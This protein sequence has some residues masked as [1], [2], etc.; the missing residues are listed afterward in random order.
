MDSKIVRFLE[1]N[2]LLSLA[3]EGPYAANCF[4][5][6]DQKTLSLVFASDEETHHMK[7]ISKNP[8]VAGTIA[9]CEKRVHKI[10]GVQFLA[11]TVQA[12]GEQE[13]LYLKTFP[14]AK[15]M[16]PTIWAL[17]L[18]WVKMTDNTLGFKTKLVWRR[19]HSSLIK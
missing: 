18:E 2:H 9:L 15:A 8:I 10:Q 13:K 19:D 14:V 17:R 5:V 1:R 11:K 16:K 3:V 7:Q 4:Y 6:F 12:S